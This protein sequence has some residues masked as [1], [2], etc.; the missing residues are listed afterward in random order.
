MT[1]GEIT[2]KIAGIEFKFSEQVAEASKLITWGKS[3]IDEAVKASPEA[4]M[5]WSAICLALPLL[6]VSA[7]TT[8]MHRDGFY[9]VTARMKF[10]ISLEHS[11]FSQD[12]ASPETIPQESVMNLYKHILEFQLR[13]VLR[14]FRGR[15]KNLGRDLIRRE[16]WA[17]MLKLIQKIEADIYKDINSINNA[18]MRVKLNSL[19]EY[20]KQ[21]H[22]SNKQLLQLA[23]EQLYIST[24]TRDILQKMLD[25]QQNESLKLPIEPD[26]IYDSADVHSDPECFEQTRSTIRARLTEWM[27]EDEANTVIWLN[28]HAGTGKS[29][30]ARTLAKRFQ[31]DC[32]LA[33]SYFIKRGKESRNSTRRIIPTIAM[34]LMAFS[35]GF[36]KQLRSLIKTSD[37]AYMTYIE[38]MEVRLQFQQLIQR[39]LE[40]LDNDS[41][42]G[43]AFTSVNNIIILDALDECNDQD[44]LFRILNLFFRLENFKT[45]SLKLFLTSRPTTAINGHWE[46][47]EQGIKCRS[48]SLLDPEFFEES[49]ADVAF[50]LRQNFKRIKLENYDESQHWPE[51]K[52]MDI[53]IGL[54]TKPR[55]LFIYAYTLIRYVEPRQANPRRRLASWL[56]RSDTNAEKLD[57]KLDQMYKM[58]LDEIWS[59]KAKEG[60]S[61]DTD[62]RELLANMLRS[63]VLIASSLSNKHLIKLLGMDPGDTNLLRNLSAVINV[64]SE[65]SAPVEI[66]H[67]SFSDF[68]LRQRDPASIQD[69]QIN[70][71]ETHVMLASKCLKRMLRAGDG[72]KRDICGIQ[73]LG[74]KRT[75]IDENVLG[76]GIPPD[77]KY[78][79]LFWVYHLQKYREEA[80]D[81]AQGNTLLESKSKLLSKVE[82]F[83]KQ[84]FLHWLEALS[85]L[86]CISDGVV[87][88]NCLCDLLTVSNWMS[89]KSDLNTDRNKKSLPESELTNLA[90][91]ARRFVLSARGGIEQAPLQAYISALIFSPSRSLTRQNYQYEE[92]EWM[93]IT[94]SMQDVWDH[95]T[96]VLYGCED[97]DYVTAVKFS[98][99]G[100]LIA[101]GTLE[102]VVKIWDASSGECRETIEC[103]NSLIDAV[104]FSADDQQL[105]AASLKGTV[106]VWEVSNGALLKTL[107]D[108]DNEEIRCVTLSEYA[109]KVA[110][111][112]WSGLIKIRD[113]SSGEW[114]HTLD[115]H[116]EIVEQLVFSGDCKKLVS[117]ARDG[118]IKVWDINRAEIL[119][120]LAHTNDVPFWLAISPDSSRIAYENEGKTFIQYLTHDFDKFEMQMIPVRCGAF[121]KDNQK[122]VVAD[123]FGD[124]HMLGDGGTHNILEGR[125]LNVDSIDVSKDCERI[126]SANK[127]G[128][129]KIWNFNDNIDIPNA[130]SKLHKVTLIAVSGGGEF[131]ASVFEDNSI[132]ISEPKTGLRH[133]INSGDSEEQSDVRGVK[134]LKF[135]GNGEK[136]AIGSGDATFKIWSSRKGALLTQLPD[137]RLSTGPRQDWIPK[138]FLS[139]DGS[140]L[141]VG[142]TDGTL[143]IWSVET[144]DPLHKLHLDYG[145]R[146]IAFSQDHEQ[147]AAADDPSWIHVPR[148]NS[149]VKIW[150]TGTGNLLKCFM[151][152][153]QINS[154]A[155]APDGRLAV[156]SR[157]YSAMQLGDTYEPKF[158]F[159]ILYLYE[160]EQTINTLGFRHHG[161]ERVETVLFSADGSYLCTDFGIIATDTLSESCPLSAMIQPKTYSLSVDR[162]WIMWDQRK[163]VWLPVE[164]SPWTSIVVPGLMALW[165][166]AGHSVLVSFSDNILPYRID[167]G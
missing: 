130:D 158:E 53:V 33:A 96:Q 133:I 1:D 58:V 109:E 116:H 89:L 18:S 162:S 95:C 139:Y 66:V 32:R 128:T 22:Q 63:L 23:T 54:A 123:T 8:Q 121:S 79:C 99:S 140:F 105:S 4:S 2:Y 149:Q 166:E 80:T 9:Y 134:T 45:F 6:T 50:Y 72:L 104:G 10:Y 136:L 114:D 163:V 85:L 60:P 61:L 157:I 143:G 165:P 55:P 101:S 122:L 31:K 36:D 76:E 93:K 161:S 43:A 141:G 86:G 120:S 154:L 3:L 17:A 13:S 138:A 77:L 28:G 159:S 46:K 100:K 25:L 125:G 75:E 81:D 67:K 59:E 135:S 38:S 83:L 131:S 24:Q 112:L 164:I 117:G 42:G 132:E 20:T 84:H 124:F 39:P 35:E 111:G 156:A 151:A 98:H 26:A 160:D 108:A 137:V 74:K 115:G 30:I 64:P 73:D 48:L 51:D 87:A 49:A 88:M 129:L 152:T 118:T 102:G 69:F 57:E 34:Q 155:Y 40:A 148:R 65:V 37:S 47:K 90:V 97:D 11:L 21:I 94:S 12:Q 103:R 68:I 119:L 44:A 147:V 14:F 15:I 153:E 146:L 127:D 62:E 113:V 70:I 91:D 27:V 29:T 145:V 56:K 107:Q 144:G 7:E 106:Q 78:A 150:N 82:R 41:R 16:D 5:A 126:V 71:G 19:D 92:P 52:D 167:T 142:E 110:I